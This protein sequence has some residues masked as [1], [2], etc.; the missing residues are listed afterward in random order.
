ME[1]TADSPV[2][3]YSSYNMTARGCTDMRSISWQIEAVPRW[4]EICPVVQQA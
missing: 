3:F 2:L 1:Y 4:M